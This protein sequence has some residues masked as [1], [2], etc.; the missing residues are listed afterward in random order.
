MPKRCSKCGRFLNR[1]YYKIPYLNGEYCKNCVHEIYRVYG[2]A[3]FAKD[4]DKEGDD[5]ETD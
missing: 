2:L 1:I 3:F 4:R 5:N